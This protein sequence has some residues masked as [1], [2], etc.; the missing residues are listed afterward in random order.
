MPQKIVYYLKLFD[1]KVTSLISSFL[2][3]YS[4]ETVDKPLVFTIPIFIKLTLYLLLFLLPI[5]VLK[6]TYPFKKSFNFILMLTV[7][8]L[9]M[10]IFGI[11]LGFVQML[12]S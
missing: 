10:S 3:N 6:F 2:K 1:N 9:I 4:L 8:L 12:Y 5:S 11:F 7:F